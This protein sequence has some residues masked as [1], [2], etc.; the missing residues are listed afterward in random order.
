MAP[1]PEHTL[2]LSRSS[3]MLSTPVI[4]TPPWGGAIS[5]NVRFD[6]P[7]GDLP[8]RKGHWFCTEWIVGLCA[9]VQAPFARMR[10]LVRVFPTTNACPEKYRRGRC[11]PSGRVFCRVW[12]ESGFWPTTSLQRP[13]A[14]TSSDNLVISLRKVKPRI[15]CSVPK[16]N[17]PQGILCSPLG[18][19]Q[20]R[21]FPFR[22]LAGISGLQLHSPPKPVAV[23]GRR[24]S[25]ENWIRNPPVGVTP[26]THIRFQRALSFKPLDILLR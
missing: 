18:F 10:G 15:A 17:R 26:P 4:P 22:T 19:T 3:R 24:L 8:R 25:G 14:G 12:N 5:Q 6:L 7:R 1:L 16:E 13:V 20:Y 2:A 21:C 23:S 9:A 11:D